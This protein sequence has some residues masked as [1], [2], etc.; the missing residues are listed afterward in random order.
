MFRK[1]NKEVGRSGET[2][3]GSGTEDA[4]L[5]LS[6]L[7]RQLEERV[8]S[9]EGLQERV[10]RLEKE[11]AELRE[12][13]G[14]LQ[15]QL[16]RLAQGA[17]NPAGAK[18]TEREAAHLRQAN[19]RL[20]QELAVA[21]GETGVVT[22]PSPPAVILVKESPPRL[23]R[24]RGLKNV[25]HTSTI[26]S[27][28]DCCL[29]RLFPDNFRG[30]TS[31][32]QLSQE[33]TLLVQLLKGNMS[34]Q[35]VIPL[36]GA[37]LDCNLQK[38]QDC[39]IILERIID[40][41]HKAGDNSI[42]R[43][44][45]FGGSMVWWA[46][47]EVMY[48]RRNVP[49]PILTLTG[50]PSKTLEQQ[51]AATLRTFDG[52]NGRLKSIQGFG[53]PSPFMVI[54]TSAH[55]DFNKVSFSVRFPS[56]FENSEN[57]V[58]YEYFLRSLAVNLADMHYVAL[59][60]KGEKWWVCDDEFSGIV[61]LPYEKFV[62]RMNNPRS[63]VMLWF[64][65]LVT[66]EAAVSDLSVAVDS[67]LRGQRS[68]RGDVQEDS[69][70]RVGQEGPRAEDVTTGRQAALAEGTRAATGRQQPPD[71]SDESYES[72]DSDEVDADEDDPMPLSRDPVGETHG[73]TRI[74]HQ[75]A[76]KKTEESFWLFR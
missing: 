70:R 71:E 74:S 72:Y 66:P 33:S 61:E 28:L 24:K 30:L 27:I 3:S 35:E 50:T 13:Q 76:E 68:F 53:K 6:G 25:C 18:N 47:G 59:C 11:N 32:V 75:E 31:D 38:Y 40:N 54:R 46:D 52:A 60:R 43:W 20:K 65:E 42:Y 23:F 44:F 14:K 73:A 55:Y 4:L 17:Q 29:S 34:Y 26:L 2:G 63:T 16:S 21:R 45:G 62:N 7:L 51:L 36:L 12:N 8:A 69:T 67:Q 1:R 19:A 49:R 37:A 5:P 10:E 39:A 41:M 48:N 22:L 58:Y 9:V 57:P 15:Q 56:Y 64:Y